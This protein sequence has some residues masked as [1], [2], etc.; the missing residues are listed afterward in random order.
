MRPVL[1]HHHVLTALLLLCTVAACGDDTSAGTP[2][3]GS[4]AAG[5]A[6]DDGECGEDQ[7]D[8]GTCAELYGTTLVDGE[9][10]F[11][12]DDFPDAPPGV[13]YC[14]VGG[15]PST[16]DWA[17]YATGMTKQELVEYWEGALADA[18]YT[19]REEAGGFRCDRRVVAIKD[20]ADV[21]FITI[22]G[23]LKSFLISMAF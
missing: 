11:L 15:V 13:E 20:G 17:Y 9:L 18:G 10:D 14:G 22:D 23:S 4:T 1:P 19:S 8:D 21:A 2:D 5:G 3:A 6:A 16:S 12:P 7:R